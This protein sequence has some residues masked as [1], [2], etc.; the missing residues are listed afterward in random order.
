MKKLLNAAWTLQ[1][2]EHPDANLNSQR[3]QPPSIGFIGAGRVATTFAMAWSR[4]GEDVCAV[5][6]RSASSALRLAAACNGRAVPVILPGAQE[7]AD[8]CSLVFVTV[9]DDEI[10]SVVT[11]VRWRQGQSVVHCS[12]ATEVSALGH[13]TD[14]GAETGGFHP[15]QLFANPE[16]ALRHLPGATVA[17]EADGS[18]EPE[19]LRLAGLLEMRPLRLPAGARIR[20]HLAANLA[21]SGLLAVL[22][23]A[24]DVWAGC[25]LPRDTALD[26]LLPLVAG[27]L[28]AARENGLAQAVSGPVARGDRGVISRH[29]DG[30]DRAGSDPLLYVELLKRLV[31]LATSTGRLS[32]T[33]AEEINALLS[34]AC[35]NATERRGTGQT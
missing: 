24:E 14:A 18:L 4:A 33:D 28:A 32:A 16:V 26:S 5:T 21:A 29:L 22:K 3:R 12:A 11:R 19:L 23:E 20:Y 15:L 17:I 10:G 34:G 6:S 30:L 7:V 13:A 2:P 8:R 1:M 9:P 35:R 27:A 25:G 31:E